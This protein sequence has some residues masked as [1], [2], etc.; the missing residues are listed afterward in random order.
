MPARVSNTM[1]TKLKTI[2]FLWRLHCKLTVAAFI[3]STLKPKWL[4]SARW[5]AT[6]SL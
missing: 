6:I 3:I 1:I 5:H 4:K 2:I